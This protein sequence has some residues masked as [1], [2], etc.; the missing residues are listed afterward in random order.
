MNEIINHFGIVKYVGF[1]VGLGGNVLI[2]HA[3]LYPGL[4][5]FYAYLGLYANLG[6][7]LPEELQLRLKLI[8]MA[9]A[10]SRKISV[11]IFLESNNSKLQLYQV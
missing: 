6:L 8:F 3:L 7:R 11:L 4:A 9:A 5:P 1:G 2:R 10:G